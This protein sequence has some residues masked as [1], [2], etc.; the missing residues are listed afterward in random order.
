MTNVTKILLIVFALLAIGLGFELYIL[1]NP[2]GL[3]TGLSTG[4]P[5]EKRSISGS[6]ATFVEIKGSL[7]LVGFL[8]LFDISKAQVEEWIKTEGVVETPT[9]SGPPPTL[10]DSKNIP[11]LPTFPKTVKIFAGKWKSLEGV[12]LTLEKGGKEIKVILSP[13]ARIW[14][15]DGDIVQ[16]VDSSVG[17]LNTSTA[18]NTF[19]PNDLILL[20]NVDVFGDQIRASSIVDF[21]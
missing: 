6:N 8:N 17:N 4:V 11:S 14:L 2:V 20:P 16:I 5:E 18:I 10:P 9:F 7:A 13:G 3:F 21:R 15:K 12:S 1:L 19:R